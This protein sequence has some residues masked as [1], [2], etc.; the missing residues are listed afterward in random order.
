MGRIKTSITKSLTI[1]LSGCGITELEDSKLR[2]DVTTRKGGYQFDICH[3]NTMRGWFTDGQ[4]TLLKKHSRRI[5]TTM[6]RNLQ[7][8]LLA[9]GLSSGLLTQA[10]IDAQRPKE[11]EPTQDAPV[12]SRPVQGILNLPPPENKIAQAR[13]EVVPPEEPV[14]QIFSSDPTRHEFAEDVISPL[15]PQQA[16]Y[17]PSQYRWLPIGKKVSLR[18]PDRK[19]PVQAY[20]HLSK[21]TFIQVVDGPPYQVHHI[22]ALEQILHHNGWT[23]SRIAE[24]AETVILAL[25]RVILELLP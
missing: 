12:Q 22:P 7:Q 15:L 13:S 5:V 8:V 2:V 16:R 9:D 1:P 10:E 3:G 21:D 24:D 4:R 18:L 20:I 17:R 19:D 14:H 23:C 6:S 11:T 25:Q